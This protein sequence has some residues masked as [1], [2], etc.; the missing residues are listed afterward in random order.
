[1]CLDF[2]GRSRESC[3]MKKWLFGATALIS[4]GLIGAAIY[5]R[6]PSAPHYSA[7]TAREAAA[8]YEARII[9]DGYG[10]P[11]VSAGLPL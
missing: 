7:E 9:R 6:T 1:M 5:L 2:W 4:I 3:V 8:A 10:V 11:H